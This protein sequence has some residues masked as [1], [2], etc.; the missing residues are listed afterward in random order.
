MGTES[1]TGLG[2]FNHSLTRIFQTLFR[3]FMPIH[4]QGHRCTTKGK[5]K[6]CQSNTLDY[7]VLI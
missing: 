4:W 5:D 3:D 7:V 6:V 2:F 1:P